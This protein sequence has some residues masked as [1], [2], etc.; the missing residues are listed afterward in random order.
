MKFTYNP[1]DD[2]INK[3]PSEI[4]CL[5]LRYLRLINGYAADIA[6]I[7]EKIQQL[8]NAPKEIL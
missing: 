8:P 3:D 5:V 4:E 2:P 6:T 7:H 1:E